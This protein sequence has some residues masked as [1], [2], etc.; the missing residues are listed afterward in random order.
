MGNAE[1][2]DTTLEVLV[3]LG[4]LCDIIGI[5]CSKA[6]ASL[7]VL[8]EKSTVSVPQTAREMRRGD[9]RGCQI[10]VRA[11]RMGRECSQSAER[12]GMDGHQQMSNMRTSGPL[13][14]CLS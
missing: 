5:N 2:V 1:G 13:G 7:L 3:F 8:Q 14:P 12:P 4:Q 10:H 6:F 11:C 9:L